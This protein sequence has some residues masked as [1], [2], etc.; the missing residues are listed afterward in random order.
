MADEKKETKKIVIIGGGSMA[1]FA[2]MF[3]AVTGVSMERAIE[4]HLDG[5]EAEREL[6]IEIS[7]NA[8]PN[9]TF[10]NA[11]NEIRVH[12]AI[13]QMTKKDVDE[14]SYF[15]GE[16]RWLS[17]FHRT[18]IQYEGGVY[19]STEH[20]FQAAKS[21]DPVTRLWFEQPEVSCGAAKRRGREIKM[22]SDWE[23]IKRDVMLAVLRV[24]FLHPELRAKLLATHPMRLVEGN[25]HGDHYWGVCGGNG[26][27]HLG[28]LLMQV[29]DEIRKA[30]GL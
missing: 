23:S 15:V 11:V 30:E 16:Y 4:A 22:R 12:D 27:N 20:A 19:P 29:R 9:D 18:W 13:D 28:I 3:G 1:A 10:E 7:E 8:R 24:K 25:S 21:V 17:N 14:I 26:E 6:L 2:A 5:P